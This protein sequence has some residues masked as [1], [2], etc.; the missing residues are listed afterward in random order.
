MLKVN[1]NIAGSVRDSFA[2][3]KRSSG[4]QEAVVTAIPLDGGRGMLLPLCEMHRR[5]PD[6]IG[7]LARWRS[8]NE[9]AYTARFPVTQEGTARWL[10]ERLLDVPD[11]VLFLVLDA[12]GRPVGHLGFA[13]GLG[14]ED[15]LEVDNVIRGDKGAQPGLMGAAMQALVKW[16]RD[17]FG[18]TNI[19]LRVLSDNAHA[20]A[21]YQRLGFAEAGRIPLR[22]HMHGQD[23]SMEPL[24]AGDA[25]APDAEFVRM[26]LRP[27]AWDAVEM[28]LTAGPSVTAREVAYSHDAARNGWNRQWS[29][30]IDR[31]EAEV[32]RLCGRKHALATSSCTGALHVSLLACGIGP[33][34]EVIV[35]DMT[36]VATGNA[37]V[38]C[39]ATPVFVDVD[40][41]DWCM[42]AEAF[43]QAITP[44]T[45]AVMPVFVYGQVPPMEKIRAIAA[46]HKLKVIEDIAPGLGA[47][48][49]GLA[50]GSEGD[51]S[52]ISF[53]GAKVAVT[54]EGGMIVTD[55]EALY[56]KAHLLWDQGRTPGTFNIER[57]GWKYKISNLQAA[58]GLGQ[59][60]RLDALVDAKRRIFSWYEQGLEGVKSLSFQRERP[61]TRGIYWMSSILLDPDARLGREALIKALK[62]ANVDTR[63]TYPSMSSFGY[64]PR[65]QAPPPVSLAIAERGI[66]LPSGVCLRREQVDYICAQLRRILA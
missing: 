43:R 52:C 63:P 1:E 47:S 34:D 21:F 36:W 18:P 4:Y 5:D 17:E 65:R 29:G 30:Y 54:G 16:G 27:P 13:N 23:W 8:E 56:E 10:K 53:Q 31:F 62:A 22:R 59:V 38:Y 32:A 66:N 39:G 11:R 35:P 46:E 40:P 7:L 15:A 20:I 24:E 61:E 49:A 2:F 64:W 12:V 25:A 28:I 48:R 50:G 51:I 44:R 26:E 60:E 37:V 45:K 3:L 9:S 41:V 42:D 33:G 14:L 19:Y 6:T 55:D 58:F 57:L